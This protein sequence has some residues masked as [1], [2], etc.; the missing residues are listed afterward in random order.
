MKKNQI[1]LLILLVGFL[2]VMSSCTTVRLTSWKDESSAAKVNNIVVFALSDK[3]EYSQAIEDAV[4]TKLTEKGLKCTKSLE[5]MAPNQQYANEEL[6]EKVLSLGADAV[7][8]FVPKGQDKSVNYTPPTYSGYYR[9]WYGG[10]YAVSP[11]YYSEST[12]YN[13]QAN[14]Y[15]VSDEKLVWTGDLST[16]DPGSIQA[17]SY[18]I[19]NSVYNDWLKRGLVTAAK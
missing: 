9:G 16:T 10:A 12:T 8:I 11:G 2:F 15:T 1:S 17:V 4:K 13:I 14:L 18:E 7:L 3:L 19:A 6:K 5:F